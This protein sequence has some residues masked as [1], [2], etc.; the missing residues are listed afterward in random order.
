MTAV[1]DFL[2]SQREHMTRQMQAALVEIAGLR[3]WQVWQARRIAQEC[4]GVGRYWNK[5]IK[6]T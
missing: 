1:G 6:T 3:W 5:G 2:A 4:L